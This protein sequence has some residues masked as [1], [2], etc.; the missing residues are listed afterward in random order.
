MLNY[1][2]KKYLL[3]AR[4]NISSWPEARVVLNK[5]AYMVALFI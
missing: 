2:G 4:D 5:E 1:K 3:V